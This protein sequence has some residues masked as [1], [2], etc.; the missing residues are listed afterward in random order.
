[1]ILSLGDVVVVEIV[2]DFVDFVDFVVVVAEDVVVVVAC[3]V[4]V[5]CVVVV[6]AGWLFVGN[7][8]VVDC[9]NVAY[10][11][12]Y[13][14]VEFVVAADVVVVVVEI[15]GVVEFV[16]GI[17][18]VVGQYVFEV[19]LNV[20]VVLLDVEEFENFVVVVAVDVVVNCLVH[21]RFLLHQN[22]NYLILGKIKKKGNEKKWKKKWKK[23]K[24]KNEKWKNFTWPIDFFF[25]FILVAWDRGEGSPWW[26]VK[27]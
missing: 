25:D 24:R 14:V 17:V 13:V 18:F 15:V 26:C 2:V 10:V 1:L 3:I 20:F 11:V 6:V 27:W 5:E 23:G 7:I 22:P 16:G 21:D 19:V 4:N 8:V 9:D 12:E